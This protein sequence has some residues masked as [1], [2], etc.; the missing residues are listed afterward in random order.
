MSSTDP[1]ESI[2][3]T[4]ASIGHDWIW[5]TSLLPCEMAQ[6]GDEFR[7]LSFSPKGNQWLMTVRVTLDGVPAVAFTCCGTP[8]ACVVSFRKRWEAENLQFFPDK[9]A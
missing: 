7:G 3:K 6:S 5:L 4:E 2:L 9:Y 1:N 8:T